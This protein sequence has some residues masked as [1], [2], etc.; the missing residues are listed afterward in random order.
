MIRAAHAPRILV[1]DDDPAIR[2]GLSAEL[3]AAGYEVVGAA[4]GDEGLR[5]FEAEAPDLVLTDLAMPGSDGYELIAAVR[6]RAK[7]P[8]VVLSVRGV[9]ADKVR[10]LDLGA[11]DYVT[12]PFS[13]HELL[14]RVRAQLRRTRDDAA[15]GP[16]EFPGL[17]VD[18]ERRLVV[19]EGR[20]VR[21]TPTEFSI[22]EFLASRAGKPVTIAQIIGRV[23]HG[24]PGT[25]P[26][27]VRV[28]VG[29]L[30]RKL[31]PDPTRPRFLVTEPWVGY[32]FVAEPLD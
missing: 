29:S 6:K 2:R 30:R 32:R 3:Q 21:L 16:L 7:T 28:H 5:R 22:L 14:A 18:R 25:T 10:A 27:A 11:D 1:V 9:E 31:E 17:V 19:V 26:D 15:P 23:W 20:E 12:K 8:I 24:A 4:D 13:V